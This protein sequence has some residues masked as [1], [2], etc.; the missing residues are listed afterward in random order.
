VK[1]LAAIPTLQCGGA[2]RVISVLSKEWEI[3]NEVK[4]LVFDNKKIAYEYSGELINLNLG[5]L[6][7]IFG[8]ILQFIKRVFVLNNYLKYNR[9]DKIISFTES[10]NLPITV[11][12]LLSNNLNKLTV[13]IRNDPDKFPFFYK[14]LIPLIYR[15]PNKVV[16]VSEGIENLLKTKYL[17]SN[18]ILTIENP[19]PLIQINKI[20]EKDISYLPKEKYILAV[21][22]LNYQKGFDRLIKC[23]SKINHNNL[24]LVIIG[25]GNE[26][27]N[28]NRI[29]YNLGMQKNVIMLGNK[30]DIWSWYKNAFCFVLSSRYE[31]YPNVIKE[32]MSQGCPVIAVDCNYGPSEIISNN[33]NGLLVE[34]Y[35]EI[36]LKN[37]ILDLLKNKSKRDY[38]IKNANLYIKNNSLKIIANK[39]LMD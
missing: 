1:I 39:W 4:I 25:E 33:I 31:G 34:N 30:R 8:K 27:E 22:R 7:N 32:A 28:L 6:D 12:A 23:F 5:S 24:K 37:C 3:N 14:I 38:L 18:S 17:D 35:S 13:S 19:P 15:L 29:I 26:R 9:F 20:K 10:F 36:Q 21:G 11:A 16:C 2:E